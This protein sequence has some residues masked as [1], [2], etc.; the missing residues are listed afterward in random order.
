MNIIYVC[1]NKLSLFNKIIMILYTRLKEAETSLHVHDHHG[2][3]DHP[4]GILHMPPV[5]VGDV[6]HSQVCTETVLIITV[7]KDYVPEPAVAAHASHQETFNELAGCTCGGDIAVSLALLAKH[8]IKLIA[9]L[10]ALL[11]D[12]KVV[13]AHHGDTGL[14]ARRSLRNVSPLMLLCSSSRS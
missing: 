6:L 8:G 13:H 5:D 10:D 2:G 3:C 14:G 4:E 7:L 11:G 9:S 1:T 12:E